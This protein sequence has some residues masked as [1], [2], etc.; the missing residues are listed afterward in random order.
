MLFQRFVDIW[1]RQFSLSYH[2]GENFLLP[3]F[4]FI[5]LRFRPNG[6]IRFTD[7]SSLSF[8]PNPFIL[9]PGFFI[10]FIQ[11]SLSFPTYYGKLAQEHCIKCDVVTKL[12]LKVEGSADRVG[13][14]MCLLT[15]DATS[16]VQH[17]IIK[18]SLAQDNVRSGLAIYTAFVRE[19]MKY[20]E[21]PYRLYTTN[22]GS[23]TFAGMYFTGVYRWE[24]QAMTR[25][26]PKSPLA[27]LPASSLPVLRW[28]WGRRDHWWK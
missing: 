27:A 28:A 22:E 25:T 20:H 8:F 11:N 12:F 10:A 19:G 3:Y 1:C 4:S 24:S 26:A 7:I 2:K 21:I 5:I 18:Q 13:T 16:S 23:F 14:A 17:Q 6:F 15:D 9:S